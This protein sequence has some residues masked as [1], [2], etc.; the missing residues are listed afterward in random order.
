VPPIDSYEA[1][2]R[3][4][5]EVVARGFTA[6]KTNVVIPG[7]PARGYGSGFGGGPTD[8]NVPVEI[9]GAIEQQLAAFT[10][11]VGPEVEIA[12]T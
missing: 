8:Q 6:L 2:T 9:L 5:E 4:G 7:T 10:E 1:I 11:G 3:L 12:L